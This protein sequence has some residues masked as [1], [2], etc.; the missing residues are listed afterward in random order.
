MP[1]KAE[2][3]SQMAD[4][5]ATQLVGSWKEWTAFLTTAARLYKY[6]F[7]EQMMIY[8]QRP[9]ATA[10]AE[11]DLWNEKM[12]RYV[13]RGSKGIALVD[14]SGD[15]PRL[16]YVFDISDTGTREHSRTPWLWQLEEQHIGPVSA[17]LERSYGVA[18]DDLAQQLTDVAGK[19]AS[20]YWDEHQRDF[21][22]IV[23]G[24]FLAEYDDYNIEVQF[25]SAATVSI[26]YALMSRCGLDT[27]QYFQHEDFMPIFDFNTP[28]T[29]GALGAAVSQI[30]QQ[31]LRQI[32]V[33]IQN[34]EREQL[35]ERS[36]THG[37]QPDLHDERRLSD[38][39]PEADRTAGEA[40][41]QVRQDAK[42][43][44]EGTPSPD[45]QSA[46]AD[47]EAV[48]A[49]HRDR[50]DSAEPS[51]ADD[52]PTGGGSGR[53]GAAE[54]QRPDAL[55]G[56]DEHLQGSG[57]GDSDDGAYSQLSFFLSEAE[58]IRIIDE[59]ENVKTSSA[60][61][62]AQADIDHV[63]RLG[64]NTYRQRERIV[65]AF[66]EQKSTAEI[67]DTLKNLY[68]GGNGIGSITAWYAE[69]GIHLSHG[70][71]ARYDKSAQVISWESAAERIGQ[72]LQD[73]QFATNVEL[74]EAAGYERS[75]LSERFWELYHDFS[76]EARE[77]GYLPSLANNPGRGF[78]EE[79][80]WLTEQLK[81]PEFR[82][83]LAEEYAAFW[84]AY[85]QDRDLLRFHYHKPKEIWENLR[86][87]SLPRTTFTS[88][89]TEVPSVKQFIS[90][91]EIDAAMTRGS[92]FEGGK[93]RVFTF[94]QE[95]HTDKEKVDFLKH[96]Y[97]IGGHSH[98]LSGA[99][100]SDESHDG[101][102]LHYKKDGCPDVHFTWEK[103]AK[104]ITDLIQKGRYLTEQEQAEYDKI[105]AEKALAESEPE[106]EAVGRI[107][108]LGTNGLPG[109]SVEYT[110]AEKFIR[111]IQEDTD[112]GV[113]IT[114]VLYRDTHGNTI[115]QDFL[116]ELD[117][118]PKGFRVEDAPA[119][120][121]EL[122]QEQAEFD[123]SQEEKVLA[124][125]DT[126]EAQQPNPTVWEYN[127][128]KE[129]HP[130]DM[131]L[132]Q[133]GDF[134]ELYGED[135]KTAATELDLNLTLRAIPG[136]GYVEMCGFPAN[137]LEQV[138]EQLRDKHDVT[139]SAIPEG[140]KERQ[141]YSMPSIDHEA[142]QHIN[143]QEAEFGAD[144]TRVFRETE[145]AAAPT[146]RELHEQYKPIVLAAVMGDVPYRNACGHSDHENA[147]I[148]GNAAIRR[149][150]LGSGNMELLRLYSDTPEFRQRL[151][152]EIIDETYPKL[153]ELLHPLSDNDIDKAIQDWNGKI[154]SKH[155]VVRYM[156]KHGREKDTAA[157]LAHEF[158]GGDG[159][160][161][162]SVRPE[163][164]EGTVLPWPKVQRR[165]AQ[166]IKE[167]RFYT[168]AEQDRFD[169]IDPIAIREALAERGIVN[170]ELVDEEKLDND[171]F[172]QR[173]MADVEAI[174]RD[175]VPADEPEQPS[176]HNSRVLVSDEEYAAARGTLR[177]RTSYDPA[178]PPY[179]VGDTVY[180]DD[181]P[182][183][184]TELRD[185]TVQLLP[186]G[187][188][189]PIY[190]AESRERFEQLLR[191]DNRNDFYTEFLPVNL[192]SVDQ[193]LRDVLAHGLIG[194]ADKA[195]LCEL[196]RNGKSNRE[197][198]LWLSR[199]YPNIVETMELETGETADYRTMPEGIELEVLDADEKRLAM[200][201]FQWSEV[202]PLLRGLYARQL[203][204]FG[205][206]RPEPAAE[207]PAYHAETVAVY[208]GDKNNLPY[209]V[210]VQTM[211]TNEPEPPTPAVEPEKT[212]DEVLDE[213]PVS[214][215]V[216]GE[217]QTFP[218]V[219]AAEEA[220]YEEYKA[221]LRRTAEN[222]RIT[223]DHLGEG[224]P[225]A[226]FQANV[227]AIKL[228]KY[229]EE[230]TEQATPEQQKI[231]SRYVGWGGLAD[232]FD[233]DKESWSKEYAQLKE[234]LTPEE[235]AAARGSTLNAHYTSP[236]VIKAIYEA[237][238]R[239]GFETGNI[240]E[241]SCGVGN[242]FGMLPEEMRN[243]RLYGVELDSISGRIAQQLY[244]KADITVAGFETT[245]RRDFYD[246]AVGNVPFRPVSGPG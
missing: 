203:D 116:A 246:L 172:I 148:E 145:A 55:G 59:A 73:G 20:E 90:E 178:V 149:A 155:A 41:G 77:A 222:F 217:W 98:A 171:P 69:D 140:G 117:P 142:E 201:F 65:A 6:P 232:A 104:R 87:L 3:Y 210:V 160:T 193:D 173:V 228:L 156:E 240:L 230:T 188:S 220:S 32:G 14:D 12:G 80:A 194:E 103:V 226:K 94:F 96:E 174:S 91:D 206:E 101:K 119:P 241:P 57:R 38:P 218:N 159:K 199:T 29:V 51:G 27:E 133:M 106:L 151:H 109:E 54:S 165:I 235:Y 61:S 242:F 64:G 11:Y 81:S 185:D 161:P 111:T 86:D 141:E 1:T 45:L 112:Y 216:N 28:A 127:G 113:P 107:E 31:V 108:Y 189:Y 179:H 190:R 146:I 70:K 177:E 88:Q 40:P 130:D 49:P 25:K 23:D 207:T 219:K 223:D 16:R 19:L 231:L 10:C 13:R 153:H 92:G 7:H 184:I 110:D 202:A 157:W 30:N 122:D 43:V 233:P 118:P 82:Q 243:S 33:T 163:S 208:P 124:D 211:R 100:K 102:G 44:P 2:M 162:F 21:R 180:L 195:E 84:T 5:V 60:F 36:V 42:S 170:G 143:T 76:E 164:P 225:K 158:D 192:D 126:M 129:R 139:I 152:R 123:K 105:Q 182:H 213:H 227:E 50:R 186:T 181:R 150:V 147:V 209:D 205:Q 229:L 221:N 115:P 35:A 63:L 56:P 198:A 46:A 22:Y 200:L 83:N 114:V 236:T 245:D 136:G 53:D 37:E 128:V 48:S 9:D 215:Q 204:G 135:A 169:N 17:M 89:L 58:Q 224:G 237:V 71:T 137:R 125:T 67:A 121:E 79:S 68:H 26:A 72:L 197:I 244:P 74:V 85:Q 47:R 75:L 134:F 175:S 24:S 191:E 212:L 196:L 34:Y 166:L 131:V 62:F 120:M 132:Y 168:E 99:M 66:E 52:A 18:G 234:L 78:P 154:E 187:M 95:P 238:G 144:G 214:I 176:P 183:Q 15:K 4:K 138:V 97:G 167:D 93:G 39:R 8:A 239:M